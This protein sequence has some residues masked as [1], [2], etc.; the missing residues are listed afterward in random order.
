VRKFG[1]IVLLLVIYSISDTIDTI[2]VYD[3]GAIV[4]RDIS[5]KIVFAK[6]HQITPDQIIVIQPPPEYWRN[7]PVIP[8]FSEK[9]LVIL[10]EA[11]N[12]PNL[13][14]H[15]FSKVGDCQLTTDTFLSGYVKGVYLVPDGYKE[16]THFFRDS[17]V[18]ES[19]TAENGLG[20]N[21]VLNPIFG[22]A[23]GHIQCRAN[24][25]PLDCELRTRKPAVVLVAIGTNWK[26]HAEITFEEKLRE[27]VDI[28]LDFGALPILATKADNIE[29]DWALNFAI[30]RVAYDYE[31]P[32]V[33]IWSAVQDLPNHGLSSPANRYLTADAWMVR[34]EVWLKT[35]E[36]ARLVL[37]D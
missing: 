5:S 28:I 25:T 12:N 15:T 23:A 13:D 4:I 29:E 3:E 34:N 36:I 20:V 2:R 32:L 10:N 14:P 18:R 37:D 31:L 7:W 6:N 9:A 8:Q 17:I 26:P 24:E 19:I 30:A 27:V 1:A 22:L 16:T 21:S 11:L 35:L 33:N